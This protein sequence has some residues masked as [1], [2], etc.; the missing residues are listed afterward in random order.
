MNF[1]HDFS[2]SSKFKRYHY[3]FFA[4]NNQSLH[5]HFFLFPLK[6]FITRENS[7]VKKIGN[8]KKILDLDQFFFDYKIKKEYNKRQKFQLS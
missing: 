6:K 1:S 2:S 4:K 3:S 7:D 5:I 8:L